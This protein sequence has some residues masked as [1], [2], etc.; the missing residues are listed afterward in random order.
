VVFFFLCVGPWV[1]GVL[2]F[3]CCNPYRLF[4]FDRCGCSTGLVFVLRLGVGGLGS[5]FAI[6][7]DV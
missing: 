5:V 6:A 2:S 3:L 7:G 1:W 4:V